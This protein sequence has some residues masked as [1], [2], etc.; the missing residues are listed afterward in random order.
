MIKDVIIICGG[1]GS[2]IKKILPNKPKILIKFNNQVLL[3]HLINL[4][5]VNN[6]KNIHLLIG[7]KGKQIAKHLNQKKFKNVSIKL[8]YDLYENLGTA[9][10][11]LQ[12]IKFFSANFVV[13]YGDLFT[14]LNISNF[15]NFHILHNNDVTLLAHPSNHAHDS[16][17][18]ITDNKNFVIKI[19][20]Q[21]KKPYYPNLTNAACYVFKKNILTNLI[22]KKKNFD[23]TQNLL[24]ILI[25]KKKKIKVYKNFEY[26]KDVGT[27]DRYFE[28][29]NDY[30]NGKISRLASN[31][32]EAIFFDRDGT[33]IKDCKNLKSIAKLNFFPNIPKAIKLINKSGFLSFLITNQP[34]IA[35]GKLTHKNVVNIHK[36]IE[37]SLEANN[38]YI[39]EYHYCP[40]HPEKGFKD[41]NKILKIE[42]DCRKPAPGLINKII[43]KY[44]ISRKNS[45]MIGDNL[46]DVI[47]GK[48]AGLNSILLQ[49][50]NDKFINSD[51][52]Y[53]KK[54]NFNDAINWIINI[55]PKIFKIVLKISASTEANKV[56]LIKSKKYNY[57]EFAILFYNFLKNFDSSV[58]LIPLNLYL[59]NFDLFKNKNFNLLNLNNNYLIKKIIKKYNIFTKFEYSIKNYIIQQSIFV[60]NSSD[61]LVIFGNSESKKLKKNES[62]FKKIKTID[63]DKYY[64]Y[65]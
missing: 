2:R 43:D 1:K 11:L 45:W 55:Y 27:P 3:D 60:F 20:R 38:S 19:I 26:I 47:A 33:I 34:G 53:L 40:H 62:F 31:Q 4:C 63:L 16:D 41:E 50:Y 17:K 48:N 8:Y 52:F 29:F 58:K 12:S 61:K 28:F 10:A 59:S 6:V 51:P 65:F 49:K 57:E 37:Q 44:K 36:K 22:V 46:V 42:C 35:K 64:D 54:K 9:G 5:I 25:N 24:P 21:K 56:I 30:K 18:L 14:N 39:N 7:Y 32:K 13:I 15:F 23:I